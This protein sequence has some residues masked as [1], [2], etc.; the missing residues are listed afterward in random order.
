MKSNVFVFSVAVAA[1]FFSFFGSLQGAQWDTEYWQNFNCKNW[2]SGPYKLYTTAEIRLNQDA[3]RFYFYRLTENFRYRAKPYLDFEAHYSAIEDK[4]INAKHFQLVQRLELEANPFFTLDN[5]ISLNW[6]NRIQ[7][8]KTEYV[9]KITSIFRHQFMVTFPIKNCGRLESIRC[10][11]EVFYNINTHR[12]YQNRF[13]PVELTFRL[14]RKTTIGV[15]L[16][17]RNF[18]VGTTWYRSIVWG[19]RLGF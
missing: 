5:R 17:L 8:V 6:R 15:F 12:F 7:F 14:S 16:M 4:P 9:W 3:T 10:Y 19:T 2:E 18:H 13:T 1:L 11:D